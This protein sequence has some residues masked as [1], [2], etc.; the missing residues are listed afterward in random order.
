MKYWLEVTQGDWAWVEK[1]NPES[2]DKK[3]GL[4]APASQRYINL[5]QPIN[6]DD[7]VFTYLTT[8]LTNN[9]KWK[10]A[11]VGISKIKNT[12]YKTGSTLKIDTCQDIEFP[13]PIKYQQ[14]KEIEDPSAHFQYAF[15][16]NMQKYLF[17]ISSKDFIS[18]LKIHSENYALLNSVNYLDEVV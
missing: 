18:I 3:R 4:K 1:V 2:P 8:T 12:Y 14:I 15:K 6:A 13:I 5:F 9:S 17:E 11:I 7:F 16:L 10:S